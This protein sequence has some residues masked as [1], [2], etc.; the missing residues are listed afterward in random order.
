MNIG[1]RPPESLTPPV[2]EPLLLVVAVPLGVVTPVLAGLL[3]SLGL[4]WP[5]PPPRPPCRPPRPEVPAPLGAL[6]PS[7]TCGAAPACC[8][9]SSAASACCCERSS[10]E[11]CAKR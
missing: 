6:P 2:Q 3:A 11:P 7:C 1:S 9:R 8:A 10:L 5:L 4:A